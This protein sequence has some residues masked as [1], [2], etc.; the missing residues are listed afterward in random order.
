MQQYR[1][2][3]VLLNF[4][5]VNSFKLRLFLKV[6]SNM[7]KHFRPKN[8]HKPIRRTIRGNV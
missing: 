2:F 8:G 5:C 4:K 1:V 3:L 6:Y 7:L